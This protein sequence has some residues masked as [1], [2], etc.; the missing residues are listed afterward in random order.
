VHNEGR[1]EANN[2]SPCRVWIVCSTLNAFCA[3]FSA[4]GGGGGGGN[5]TFVL[6]RVLHG[7]LKMFKNISYEHSLKTTF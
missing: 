6:L 2:E 5:F 3:A 1:N 7:P 4:V